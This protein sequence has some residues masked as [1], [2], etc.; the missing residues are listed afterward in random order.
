VRILVAT[1]D[2]YSHVT[3]ALPLVQRLVVRGHTVRW[4]VE[5]RYGTFVGRAGATLVPT[6]YTPSH[7]GQPARPLHDWIQ[8]F[9]REAM[10]QAADLIY[11]LEDAPTDVLLVD[12]TILGVSALGPGYPDL[13]IGMLGCVPL[14]HVPAEAQFILQ[15]TLPQCEYPVAEA[16]RPRTFFTGP[17]LPPPMDELAPEEL[18][19]FSQ[20]IPTDRPLVVVT[21]G[22]V[23]T[24]LAGLVQP[25]LDAIRDLPV[26]A[27]VQ[28]V[29][30]TVEL[31]PNALAVPWIP[32]GRVLPHASL[33]VSNGG[34]QGAQ[35]CLAAGVPMVIHGTTEDKPEV[36]ARVEWAGYGKN[37]SGWPTAPET[38]RRAIEDVLLNPRYREQAQRLA[39]Q[40]AWQDSATAAAQIL[41]RHAA[42]SEVAHAA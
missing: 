41:E 11:A 12:P 2:G 13:R 9:A 21:H 23:A 1:Y 8:M 10:A 22:T 27:L 5:K 37:V 16:I 18:A 19:R 4:L 14:L 15:A 17:L 24:D 7:E 28:A 34:Y 33:V 20:R 6:A 3:T 35:W 36:G 30:G 29:P 38:F 42:P 39:Q 40:C 31:P 25:T 26:F 32:F